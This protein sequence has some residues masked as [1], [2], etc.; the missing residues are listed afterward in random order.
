MDAAIGRLR[1]PKTNTD[2]ETLTEMSNQRP[3]VGLH[4]IVEL[5]PETLRDAPTEY[6]GEYLGHGTSKTVFL[7]SAPG[8]CFDQKILKVTKK[9]HE[10]DEDPEPMVFRAGAELGLTTC[11]L[12]EATAVDD[13]SQR[14]WH[15]WITDRTV[16]LNVIC[17]YDDTIKSQCSLAAFCCILGAAQRGFYLSECNF[18]NF[19]VLLTDNAE[20]HH[21]VIIDADGIMD[22]HPERQ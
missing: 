12:Y 19:G 15:C 6:Y 9:N 16:P 17:R 7:L 18:Y 13:N 20:E 4:I 5:P 1:K 3:D 8:K 21:V 2:E 10:R 11:L 22:M 14:R